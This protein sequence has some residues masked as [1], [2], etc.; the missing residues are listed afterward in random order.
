MKRKCVSLPQDAGELASLHYI[1]CTN[2][3]TEQYFFLQYKFCIYVRGLNEFV[4]S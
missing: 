4:L 2:Q 3:S 1:H